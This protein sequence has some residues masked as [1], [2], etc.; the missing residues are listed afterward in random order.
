MLLAWDGTVLAI[1]NA[2]LELNGYR[3]EQLLRKN[4]LEVASPDTRAFVR[5]AL[6]TAKRG[7][8]VQRDIITRTQ[9]GAPR[10][11]RALSIPV[12][13][14]GDAAAFIVGIDLRDR[15]ASD[16]R[17]RV[18]TEQLRE[19]YALATAP[20]SHDAHI[21]EALE[22]G[23]RLLRAECGV[24][25]SNGNGLKIE[26]SHHNGAAMDARR[27]LEFAQVIYN[28]RG[29]VSSE[30]WIGSRVVSGSSVHGVLLF[31]NSQMRR[32]G[33]NESDR[34]FMGLLCA[35][36]GASIERRRTRS[37]LRT[38]AYYDPLTGL[39]NRLLFQERLRDA[40]LDVSGQQNRIAVLSIDL[41]RFKDINDSLGHASG[42]RLLQLVAERLCGVA[43]ER[44]I[45]ARTGGDEFAIMFSG[46]TDIEDIRASAEQLLRAVDAPYRFDD[47]EQFM[48]ASVGIAVFP[49]DARD[50]Q[51]L[52]KHADMAMYQAKAQGRN[53]YYFYAPALDQPL[54]ARITK[55]KALRRALSQGEFT[56]HYQPIY[57]LHNDTVAGVEAL[58]RWNH[59]MRGMLFPGQFIPSAE[60]SGLIVQLD[61]WVLR[62]AARQ[63]RQWH[64]RG[65][66][67]HLAVNLSA[68][69]FHLPDLG[70]RLIGAVEEAG[71]PP[72]FLHIEITES[73]AMSDAAYAAKTV[74]ELKRMGVCVSVDDF[75]T[76]HSSLSYLRRFEID[77]MKIDRSF[78]DGIGNEEN[79]ETI[80]KTLIAMGHAL[81][82]VIVAEGVES[83]SQLEFLKQH[84][85]DRIQG[86]HISAPVDAAAAGE[87]LERYRGTASPPG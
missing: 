22:I 25:V 77:H 37:H 7:E 16:E 63:V 40:L 67:I 11:L 62:T 82:L 18:R 17:E 68:R 78:V 20:D 56:V 58:V 83:A 51:T 29:T 32:D 54:H 43:G 79:D 23:C 19:L 42:D 55:E 24:L 76:G 36:L 9:N 59:P 31:F 87:L 50:D 6:E 26:A 69:Q 38:L 15:I 2:Y 72:R 21:A 39:A 14:D 8:I 48:T 81:G 53:A 47:Y 27:V 70:A 35:L 71:I 30:T 85:C 74:C 5:E 28:E 49:E 13:P 57:D 66:K 3:L 34:D 44:G 12:G 64:E 10:P 75:G 60:A 4:I 80:V 1:N 52:L 41:D 61:E 33:F 46:F 86:F 65:H 84:G 45:V 73:V